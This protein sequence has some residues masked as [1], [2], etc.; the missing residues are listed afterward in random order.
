MEYVMITY[1]KE[2]PDPSYRIR[3]TDLNSVYS[4]DDDSLD[5]LRNR[6]DS[7]I[8]V[9]I[10]IWPQK[11]EQIEKNNFFLARKRGI[12]NVWSAFGLSPEAKEKCSEI[13]TDDVIKEFVNE[14]FLATRPSGDL[15]IWVYLLRYERHD[16]YPKDNI[17]FMMD[18]IHV[19]INYDRKDEN[20]GASLTG[21]RSIVKALL[22]YKGNKEY[23]SII[24]FVEETQSNFV[25][26]TNQKVH[27][28][29]YRIA[30]LFLRF[31]AMFFDRGLDINIPV[32]RNQK[33][34]DAIDRFKKQCKMDFY[35]AS[36]LLGIFLGYDK[37][38]DTVYELENLSIFKKKGEPQRSLCDIKKPVE[39]IKT[40]ETISAEQNSASK[41]AS[42]RRILE[43]T[44]IIGDILSQFHFERIPD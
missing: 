11:V 37:T 29:Y 24:K 13:V 5:P 20:Q 12:D 1:S 19:Y 39:P 28:G 2:A 41:I 38:Y 6:L 14:V 44:G 4:L 40:K 32:K 26:T 10:P 9:K 18:T 34:R 31:Q 25:A 30:P 22:K 36:Y 33:F 7:R 16:A 21:S 43:C 3:I 27:E 23:S 8:L 42:F 15:S 35:I 17:G